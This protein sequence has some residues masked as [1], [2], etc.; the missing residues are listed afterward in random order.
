MALF[1]ATGG[2]LGVSV[3][4]A[5]DGWA[6]CNGPACSWREPLRGEGF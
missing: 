5:R 2:Y 1:V 3:E 4:S 6:V